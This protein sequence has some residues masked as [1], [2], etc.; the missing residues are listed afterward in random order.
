MGWERNTGQWRGRDKSMKGVKKWMNRSVG[1]YNV[2]EVMEVS[3]G[4]E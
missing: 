1:T 4:S 2:K 3:G